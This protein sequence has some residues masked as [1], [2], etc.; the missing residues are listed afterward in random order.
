MLETIRDREDEMAEPGPDQDELM[1]IN[2]VREQ[3]E[4]TLFAHWENWVDAEIP[5]LGHITPRQAVK[6]P[7]GR[8]SVE[9]LLLDAE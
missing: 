8:E 5:A 9:A 6:D 4:K 7:D 1:Q 3:I 2:E